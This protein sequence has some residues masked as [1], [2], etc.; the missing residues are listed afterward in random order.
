[1]LAGS[2][3]SLGR[4]D[5]WKRFNLVGHFRF[6]H[7]PPEP[8]GDVKQIS[9]SAKRPKAEANEAAA[10]AF[11]D[12]QDQRS[13]DSTTP[14]LWIHIEMANSSDLGRLRVGISI[15]PADPHE[16]RSGPSL[17]QDLA[18]TAEPVRACIPVVA[19]ALHCV[20]VLAQAQHDEVAKV[21][22]EVTDTLDSKILV[23]CVASHQVVSGTL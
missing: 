11:H 3:V 21:V 8:E 20:E 14:E 16:A 4:P 13:P 12:L 23:R 18:R 15:E 22:R 9:I 6:P 19:H 1:M 7:N 2:I 10:R 5:G 17:E